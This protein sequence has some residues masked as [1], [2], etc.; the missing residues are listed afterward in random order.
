MAA[1]RHSLRRVRDVGSAAARS[2][3]SRRVAIL[4]R[5]I[6]L[7]SLLAASVWLAGG[8]AGVAA[9]DTPEMLAAMRSAMPSIPAQVPA[10][11]AL[12]DDVRRQVP[13]F[14]IE[15]HRWHADPAQRFVQI[16]GR[17][18]AEDGVAGQEL[19]VREVRADAVVMQFRDW[20]F[21]QPL[22]GGN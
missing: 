4:L 9:Q 14:R 20:F 12:P 1:E 6:P 21:V 3:V 22:K 8:V 10:F 11:D 2:A 17:R 13:L 5:R 18:V 19:W 15:V 16:G 7:A